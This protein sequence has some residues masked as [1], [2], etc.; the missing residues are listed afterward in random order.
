MTDKRASVYID[1]RHRLRLIEDDVA[2]RF[3]RDLAFQST[4]DV[5]F[6]TER[7]G[8]FGIEITDADAQQAATD[9][10]EFD[11][12][13]HDGLGDVDRDRE[14]DADVAATVTEDRRVDTDQFATQV[15]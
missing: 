11:D 6:D 14:T 12:L 13:G 5:I 9:F 3:E 8:G 1:R 15:H 4:L 2:A 7:F 10:P